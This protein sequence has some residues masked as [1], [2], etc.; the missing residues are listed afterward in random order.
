MKK[1]WQAAE[2]WGQAT[3]FARPNQL[4]LKY[5]APRKWCL[6]PFF[7]SLL[8]SFCRETVDNK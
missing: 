7:S 8:A 1:P 5:L 3:I 2:K 4:A 6:S